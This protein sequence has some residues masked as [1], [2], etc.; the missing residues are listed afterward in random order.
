LF[1]VEVDGNFFKT[2]DGTYNRWNLLPPF[3]LRNPARIS[4]SCSRQF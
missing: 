2:K 1:S 3:C 4:W